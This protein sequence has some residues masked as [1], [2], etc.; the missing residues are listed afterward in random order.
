MELNQRILAIYKVNIE[1]IFEWDEEKK[2]QNISKNENTNI[3][4]GEIFYW[5]MLFW[6]KVFYHHMQIIR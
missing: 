2:K 4:F 6:Q 1:N 5:F 3:Q